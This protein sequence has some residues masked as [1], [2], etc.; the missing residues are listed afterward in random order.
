VCPKLAELNKIA[1]RAP[2]KRGSA[3]EPKG[4]LEPRALFPRRA[5]AV[6]IFANVAVAL[7]AIVAATAARAA[8]GGARSA[9]IGASSALDSLRKQ[10]PRG[11]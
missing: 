4:E 6:R 11:K 5:R 8:A 3:E 7:A 1:G 2:R 9:L 10:N